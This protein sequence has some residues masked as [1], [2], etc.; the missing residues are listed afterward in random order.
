MT[1]TGIPRRTFLE[2]PYAAGLAA[3]LAAGLTAS[4]GLSGLA[5][6][7]NSRITKII[8]PVPPGGG[9]DAMA[10]LFAE[11]TKD[12][13]G[14]PI[15]DNKPGAALRIA[16]DFVKQAT[17]D[18]ATLLF[19]PASPFTI[20]PHIYKKLNYDFKNDFVAI[21]PFC[22]FDFALGVPGDSPVN[23]VA[24]YINAVKREPAKFS[25]YAVPAAGAA[26]HFV[27]AQ[28][29]RTSG[30]PLQHIPY[31]GS[32]PAMQDLIGGNVPA[33]F[34][35]TGEFI[36]HAA[37]KR[38]KVLATSGEKRSPF[39]PNVPTFAE[40]GFK[41]MAL[42]EWFGVF[43]P[44][45]TPVAMIDSIGAAINSALRRPEVQAR[46]STLGFSPY[47]LPSKEAQQRV[48]S[49]MNAWGSIVKSTGFTVEE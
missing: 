7:Q 46:L 16:I 42:S 44:A 8:V 2:L 47:S 20:Y 27:G 15:V 26:P 18:G 32:A 19:S 1:Q 40:L 41:D 25:S 5:R 6:A 31:K 3:S 43:A 37:A 13:L 48:V 34:N 45:K 36:Q 10:R 11:Q 24:D 4:L 30:L 39:F 29:A 14:T 23:T 28:F 38:V 17:P 35:L 33:A 22:Q 12:M 9:M 49:E 21:S